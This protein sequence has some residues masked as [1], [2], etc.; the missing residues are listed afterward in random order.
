MMLGLGVAA[1][2]SGLAYAQSPVLAD[3]LR[4]EFVTKDFAVKSF[5]P[6][7]W[8]NGGQQYA[9]L[10]PPDKIEG[11]HDLVRYVTATAQRE[12]LI[13]AAQLTPPGSDKPLHIEDY[14][15]SQDLNRVLIFTNSRRVWR[16]NTRGDC[17]VLDRKSGALRKVGESGPPSSLMF[18]KFSPDGSKIAYVRFNNIYVE[19]LATGI[20]ARLTN[21]GSEKIVNGTSDWVYE[22]EFSVRD[23]FRWS[24]DGKRIAY[25]QFD[26]NRVRN[27]PLVYDTG[28]PSELET[29]IA[30]PKFG[31][32]PTVRQ[33]PYPQ[34][35]TRN[36]SVRVGVSLPSGVKPAGCRFPGIRMKTT[37]PVWKGP[38]TR[39]RLF[40]ST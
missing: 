10:E 37:S 2:S 4:R 39:I 25:W 21:D 13:W 33:I 5:G 18:A 28:A 11:A 30:Y 36:S 34:P 16:A 3:L 15:L 20:A 6:V 32:Y 27:F 31:V 29:G 9:T 40:C 38:Q 12:V 35:G 23:G 26:T 8:L 19:D 7:R 22:E 24:P 14:S 1:F 17:W